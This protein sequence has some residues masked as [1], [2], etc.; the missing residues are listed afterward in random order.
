MDRTLKKSLASATCA[1]LAIPVVHAEDSHPVGEWDFSGAFLFYSEPDRV[2]AVEP[3]FNAQKYLDTDESLNIKL[4]LDTLTGASATG[5]V[6]S[7]LPQTF[8]RPSGNGSY[9][10]SAGSTPLDDTFKDTRI[11]VAVSW[12]RPSFLGTQS[13]LGFSISNE[14]DYL[15]VG[16]SA[17]FAKNFNDNNTTLS[18]GFA[19]ASDSIEPVGGA[20]IAFSRMQAQGE[21][22]LRQ[23]GSQEKTL[24]DFITGLTQII[25]EN[26][27]FQINYS[28]SMASGYLNDP[29]KVLSIVDPDSGS[30]VFADTADASLPG[31]VFENRPD[32]RTKH[33]IFGQYKRF[34][35]KNGD[36]VDTSYRYML[37]DWGISS[38]TIE[39]KYRRVLADRRFIQPRVRWYQQSA[40]DFYTPFFLA[41]SEPQSGDSAAEASADYRLGEFA[42]YTVG[43]EYGQVNQSNSWSVALEYYIQSGREPDESFG[44]LLSH[45]L[46]PD[47][48]AFMLR[49]LYDF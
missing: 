44:E 35:P 41:G 15:S 32:S 9:V 25:D 42:A 26:S 2:Q 13:D 38:H 1:L 18:S 3:V 24:I 16:G 30:P 43:L 28:L 40:A 6:P 17:S 5:A 7:S 12:S 22:A 36:V 46:F 29:Y 4:T 49:V 20:P 34:L 27:L 21:T 37:D 48:D 39:F 19:F 23:D 10:V 8:T 45:E 11:A 14:Y 31:V 47:V 33:S